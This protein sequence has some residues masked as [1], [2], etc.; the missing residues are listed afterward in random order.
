MSKFFLVPVKSIKKLTS[1][2]VNIEFD[3]LARYV[4]RQLEE[5]L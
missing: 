4:S 3:V 5:R 1:D 2:S